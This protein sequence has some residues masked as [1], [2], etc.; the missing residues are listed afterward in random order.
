MPVSIVHTVPVF[1]VNDTTTT[2]IP[3]SIVSSPDGF[4]PQFDSSLDQ[5][6]QYYWGSVKTISMRYLEV[7]HQY[8]VLVGSNQILSERQWINF[9]AESNKAGIW[10]KQD[11]EPFDIN[12]EKQLNYLTLSLYENNVE[13]DILNLAVIYKTNQ[14]SAI[15]LINFLASVGIIIG[16]GAII[17]LVVRRIRSK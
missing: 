14:Y 2:T 7:G 12:N 4:L 13:L 8:S 3:T 1:D 10:F 11:S 9:T 5:N 15:P 6:L 16:V 17:T